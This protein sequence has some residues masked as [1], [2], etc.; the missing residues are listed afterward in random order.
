[1]L[2]V[3]GLSPDGGEQG[4]MDTLIHTKIKTSKKLMGGLTEI[5]WRKNNSLRQYSR[6]GGLS[7][8]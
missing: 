3:E 1:L 6:E 5:R 7:I 4:R 8:V 2:S